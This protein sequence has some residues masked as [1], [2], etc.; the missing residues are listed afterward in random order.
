MRSRLLLHDILKDVLGS[1]KVYFQPPPSLMMQYP[2]I[3]YSRDSTYRA[4]A[5][6][7]GYHLVRRYQVTHIS[8]DPDDPVPDRVVELPMCSHSSAFNSDNLYH[9][10]FTLYF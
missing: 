8:K 10:N 6:N 7:I 9:Q 4:E 5:D 1:N 2:C 3:V